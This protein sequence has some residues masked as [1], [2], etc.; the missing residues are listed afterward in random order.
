MDSVP[1]GM[2]DE[3]KGRL[4]D[5]LKGMDIDYGKIAVKETSAKLMKCLKSLEWRHLTKLKL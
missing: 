4:K 3:V 1:A 2:G 5:M